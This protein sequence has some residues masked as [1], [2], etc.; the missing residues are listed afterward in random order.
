[1]A[2]NFIERRKAN[3]KRLEELIDQA[4]TARGLRRLSRDEVRELGR[5]YRRAATDLA[6]ARVE[7]RDRRLV[8]Y[9]NNLVVRA[10]GLIYRNESKGASAVLAFYLYDF[11]AI[12][13]RTSRYTLAVFLIFIALG[14][15]SFIATWRDDDFADFAYVSRPFVQSI[16]NHDKWWEVLN[17]EAPVGAAGIMTNNIGVGILTFALS[18]FPVVG[19]IYIL[20]TTALQFGAVNALVFKYGM[21]H[22]LWSFVAGHAVLEFTAI[23]I[24]GGA[25]LMVGW[26]MIAPGERGRRE[27]VVENGA[28]AIKLMAG[29]FPMFVIAGLIEAFISPLPIASGYR[30]AVSAA[31]AV[32][33]AAYLLKP[34]RKA[35]NGL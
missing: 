16:K 21:G 32:G 8:N 5:S 4:R 9:L 22:T 14:A 18:V 7:S 35:P 31:T 29:C 11:P 12:F 30:F 17:K 13:R 2:E 20:K 24:A 26:S 27:A 1:M 19:T 33:L 3:W 25:G 10:H 28:V 23:F 6:V 15:V 34:E